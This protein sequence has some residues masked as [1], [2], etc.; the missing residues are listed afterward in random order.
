M[1][2]LEKLHSQQWMIMANRFINLYFN[3]LIQSHKTI[4]NILALFVIVI[5][6]VL[7]TLSILASTIEY[8]VRGFFYLFFTKGFVKEYFSTLAS[9]L[10]I[11]TVNAF[12]LLPDILIRTYY[13]I[14]DGKID[15]VHSSHTLYFQ[16]MRLL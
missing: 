3:G 1:L 16:I 15:P 6:C 2:Q 11:N 14:T 7:H 12:T 10:V 8:A 5:K 4:G 9:F 13:A